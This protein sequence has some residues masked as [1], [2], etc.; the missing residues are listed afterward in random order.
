MLTVYRYIE[1]NPVR[2]ELAAAAEHYPWSSCMHHVGAKTDSLV[3]DHAVYWALG[4][5]PF[6]REAAYK[7]ALSQPLKMDEIERI[8]AATNKGW[9][10]GSER[11]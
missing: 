11:F 4:N 5:T 1:L 2:A 8:R 9:V 10:L 3:T 7:D 6:Q